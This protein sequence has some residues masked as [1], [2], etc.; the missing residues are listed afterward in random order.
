MK[1]ESNLRPEVVI[2]EPNGDVV[3]NENVIEITKDETIAYQYDSYRIN[4]PM[5]P[6]LKESIE[7]NFTEWIAYA[8]TEEAKQQV[9]Q[10]QIAEADRKLEMIETLMEVGLL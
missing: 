8:K 2:V 7:A 5:R 4:L 10:Q 1:T 9:T 3:L 6:S